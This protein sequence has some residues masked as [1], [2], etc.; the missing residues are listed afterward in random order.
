MELIPIS[1]IAG[2]LT[3][4]TPCV[5][6]L[7]PIIIGGVLSGK[8]SIKRPIIITL[9]L[10]GSIIL[11]TLLL[12][13]STILIDVP[14]EF[15]KYFSATI[16]FLFAISLIFPTIWEKGISKIS[17]GKLKTF[18]NKI[19]FKFSKKNSTSSA[20]FLGGAL[21]PIFAPCSPTYL[22][23]LGIAINGNFE[24]AIINLI[25]YAI[26]LSLIMFL[27]AFAGQK[28]LSKLNLAS[29]PKGWFKKTLGILFLIVAIGIITGY[30]KIFEIWL[31]EF[32]IFTFSTNLESGI[33][34][35][36]DQ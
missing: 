15:L 25:A 26:G 16:I 8:K 35:N 2:I 1:F 12:K 27:V 29:N 24:E 21:G 31:L 22:L 23:I 34:D 30:D 33:L 36:M 5:L 3:I 6:P 13:F 28:I 4:L 7:L 32:D 20:I 14:E 18:F 11:F 19:I 17:S 9:S 10:A